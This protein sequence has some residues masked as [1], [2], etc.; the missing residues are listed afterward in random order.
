MVLKIVNFYLQD[1]CLF[2]ISILDKCKYF[3]II[4]F[5]TRWANMMYIKL[6]LNT[7]EDQRFVIDGSSSFKVF[8]P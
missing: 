2:I 5:W 7:I 6:V 8:T 4:N 3:K 1:Y